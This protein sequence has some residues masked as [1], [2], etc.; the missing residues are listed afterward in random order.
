MPL[1]LI[2]QFGEI[3]TEYLRE[4]KAD[5]EQV[6]ERIPECWP[7]PAPAPVA[8][9]CDRMP[10]IVVAHDIAPSRHAIPRAEPSPVS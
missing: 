7:A 10:M 9:G 3:E 1:E 8:V 4:R 2:R 5:I 6:V